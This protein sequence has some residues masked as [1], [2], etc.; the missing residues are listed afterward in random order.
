MEWGFGGNWPGVA[1]LGS[2]LGRPD[3]LKGEPPPPAQDT[4]TSFCGKS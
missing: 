3:P 2:S 1:D 4:V